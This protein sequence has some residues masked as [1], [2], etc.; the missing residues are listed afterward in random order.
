MNYDDDY[1][2]TT[3]D[4]EGLIH[5]WAI[6]YRTYNI[7]GLEKKLPHPTVSI[8]NAQSPAGWIPRLLSL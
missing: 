3:F 7:E 1:A 6:S 2:R 8:E 4:I 5:G